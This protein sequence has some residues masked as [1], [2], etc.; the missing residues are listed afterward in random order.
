MEDPLKKLLRR[1]KKQVGIFPRVGAYLVDLVLLNLAVVYPF[2]AILSQVEGAFSFNAQIVCVAL[3]TVLLSYIYWTV[4]DYSFSQTIGKMVFGLRVKGKLTL[5]QAFVRNVTKPFSLLL[6]L[7]S[8]KVLLRG[9]KQR[10]SE[11]VSK[12]WVVYA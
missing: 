5:R 4:M 10:Y 3:F 12:T 8:W 11:E 1:S 9:A 2:D 7:D 6:L